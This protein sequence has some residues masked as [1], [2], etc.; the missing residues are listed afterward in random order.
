MLK[1][2]KAIIILAAVATVSV[3]CAGLIA[4]SDQTELEEQKNKSDVVITYD[5]NG[6]SFFGRSGVTIIDGYNAS[7]LNVQSD[8][9]AHIKLLEPTSSKRPHPSGASSITI[10]YT[11]H[12]LVGWYQ[13]RNLK[14]NDK[15]EVVD[16]D[17]N[18]LT[19]DE[20]GTYYYITQNA[21]GEDVK[22]TATPAYTY[23]NLW[24]FDTDELLYDVESGKYELTLY[25]G[26]VPYYQFEFYK[27]VEGEWVSFSKTSFD[28]QLAT[29]E[30]SSTYGSDYVYTPTWSEGTLVYKHTEN[31]L[32]F[33]FPKIDGTTFINAYADP[34][35]TKVIGTSFQHQGSLDI[36][37]GSAINP[38]QKIYIEA[39]E[40]EQFYISTAKQLSDYATSAGYYEILADL[41]FKNGEISWPTAFITSTFTG[42]LYSA[43][44]NT[45]TISNVN[46]VFASDTAKSGGLFGSV[47]E[48]AVLKNIKFDTVTFDVSSTG[49]RLTDTSFGLLSGNIETGANVSGVVIRNATFRIGAIR[50]NSDYAFNLLAGGDKQGIDCDAITFEIYGQ[51]L[52]KDQYN[53]T[54][55]L[56][57]VTV[58]ENG[59]VTLTFVTSNR[60]TESNKIITIWRQ[61]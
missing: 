30:G 54:V 8:G 59:D 44:G 49:S 29:T 20:D 21:D 1:K 56:D 47:A 25:A 52:I 46:A 13:T 31:G 4:C 23:D 2:I 28:W 3:L 32:S 22:T 38:V 35:K 40:G 60:Q 16:E 19:E 34:E 58:A 53:F 48:G 37:H 42:K 36:A 45:Y 7:D 55:N 24:N 17:G 61:N 33:T 50:L 27:E 11:N 10:S 43:D 51:F 15:N 14:Y 9:K 6:G 57:T 41:D 39:S 5:A 18:V 26:W 12:F